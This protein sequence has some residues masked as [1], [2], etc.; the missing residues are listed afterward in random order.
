[1]LGAAFGIWAAD[2]KSR[3]KGRFWAYGM[4][5]AAGLLL[6]FAAGYVLDAVYG[7][8]AAGYGR[9]SASLIIAALLLA[10]AAGCALWATLLR[11]TTHRLIPT[12][13]VAMASLRPSRSTMLGL[14][15]GGALS[16]ALAAFGLIRRYRRH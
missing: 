3:L 5:G 4:F 1:M 7:W 8:L 11:K 13:P 9:V 16:A 6:L 15:A 12:N 14:A 10:S 2:L